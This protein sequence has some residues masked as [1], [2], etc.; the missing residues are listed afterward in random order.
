MKT[1]TKIFAPAAIAAATVAVAAPAAAQ[2][3]D[4]VAE[5]IAGARIPVFTVGFE[6]DIDELDRLAAIVEAAS[7]DARE[8]DVE[9]KMVSLF[10]AGV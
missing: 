7:I 10:N 5:V 3:E 8:G 4:E 1:L 9:F 6:A 2:D